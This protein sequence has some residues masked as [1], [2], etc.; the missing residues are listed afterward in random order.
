MI[1]KLLDGGAWHT[2]RLPKATHTY[3]PRHG[4]YTEWPRIREVQPDTL[5]MDMH[6]M[7]YD[8]RE[9]SVV[10]RPAGCGRSPTISAI[11]DL[12]LGRALILAADDTS[13][14]A[15]PMAGQSQ[16]NRGSAGWPTWRASAPVRMGW[17]VVEGCGEGR[18]ALQ[19]L[20]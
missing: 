5:M 6:G 15:N 10:P 18:R 13:I 12:P 8:F 20:A 11:P 19:T 3:D 9:D 17:A 14:M 7:F 1:L 16:S 2:F 4:W